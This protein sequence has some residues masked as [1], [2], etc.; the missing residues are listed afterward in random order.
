MSRRGARSR[1]TTAVIVLAALA[2]GFF[3]VARGRVSGASS[4]GSERQLRSGFLEPLADSGISID[5]LQACHYL[6]RSPDEAWHFSVE[7]AAA[8]PPSQVADALRSKTHVV[9]GQDDG[10]Q[11]I[12]QQFRGQPNRGWNGIL[13][14]SGSGARLALVKNNV[15]TNDA[16]IGVGWLRVCPDSP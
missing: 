3:V 15:Q 13:T 7:I 6:R 5:V 11:Q 10:Y 9:I 14:E 12:V 4:A 2:L 16:S 1:R 8:A